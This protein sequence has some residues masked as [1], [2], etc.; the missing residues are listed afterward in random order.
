MP[1]KPTLGRDGKWRITYIRTNQRWFWMVV[2][3]W[4]LTLTAKAFTPLIFKC[5][6]PALRC[7]GL[8]LEWSKNGQFIFFAKV[9]MKLLTE[10]PFALRL[11]S[12]DLIIIGENVTLVVGK[13]FWIMDPVSS[14]FLQL[15][16]LTLLC[17]SDHSSLRGQSFHPASSVA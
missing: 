5:S 17:F 9:L 16:L 8:I 14:G 11:W 12:S 7:S 3:M 6:P 10:L 2:L 13:R 4:F 1:L 15:L